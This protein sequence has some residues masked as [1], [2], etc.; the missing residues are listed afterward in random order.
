LA[1]LTPDSAI[2]AVVAAIVRAIIDFTT[3]SFDFVF[4]RLGLELKQHCLVIG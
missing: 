2:T 1:L 3:C 4:I